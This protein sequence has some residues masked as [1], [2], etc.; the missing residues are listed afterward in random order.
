MI[1]K[2]W[3]WCLVALLCLGLWLVRL[4]PTAPPADLPPV[5]VE[6]VPQAPSQQRLGTNAK[7]PFENYQ[8]SLLAEFALDARILGREDYFMD[9]ESDLAPWDFA[10]GWG[11]MAVADIANQFSIRQSGRWYY[12]KSDR[13]PIPRRVVE[14]S[15]ANMHLIPADSRIRE[16]LEALSEG[17]RL[18][19]KGFLVE[20]RAD[21]GWRWRSSLT[22]EDTG[23]GACELV[24]VTEVN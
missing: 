21:D 2:P 13:L 4:E 3:Q 24:L 20:A 6:P 5:T 14:T 19:L 10:L 7:V 23:N 9:R 8:L 16:K 22:R 15:S 1:L 11:E 12:W 18:R 17:D